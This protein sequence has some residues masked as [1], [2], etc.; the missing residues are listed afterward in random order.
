MDF[1]DPYHPDK[2]YRLKKAL[3]RLK[4]APRAWDDELSNFL[5]SKG[6][7][8]GSIDPTLFGSRSAVCDSHKSTSGGIDISSGDKLDQLYHQKSRTPLQFFS[9]AAIWVTFICVFRNKILMVGTPLIDYVGRTAPA[10]GLLKPKSCT[11]RSKSKK[12]SINEI[13]DSYQKIVTILDSPFTVLSALRL[14][15]MRPSKHGESKY[16]SVRRS[17]ALSWK[18]VNEIFEST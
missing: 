16:I 12:R 9:K 4:Q 14:P 11:K 7:S 3:Y 8:K 18:P 2:V 13:D 15:V 1:V 10:S 17:Y 6:F 5:V